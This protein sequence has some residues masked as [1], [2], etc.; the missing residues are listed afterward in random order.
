MAARARRA[1]SADRAD[2]QEL[3]FGRL[4]DELRE[5]RVN[6]REQFKPPQ[7]DGE[8]DIDLF[9]QHFQEVAEANGWNGMATLLHLR[10]ALQ[11]GAREYGRP[12]TTEEVF[13]A[14]RSRYGLT[15]KEA[16]GRLNGLKKEPRQS[17]HDHAIEVEKLVRKAFGD[18]PVEVQTNM[19]LDAFCSSLG[20]ATLQRHLLAIRPETLTEAVQHGQEYLQVKT[21]RNTVPSQVRALEETEEGKE[22]DPLSIL[23]ETVKQL[24][25]TVRELK[26]ASQKPSKPKGCW[27]CKKDGHVRKD[28]PTHPWEPKAKQTGNGDGPQ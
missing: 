25:D 23:M 27:G 1:V 6:R 21:D 2:P 11:G 20:N 3:L 12:A 28:C 17:L 14:L 15:T 26:Q 16:R 13:A 5:L 24:A 7:F 10:E 19:M 8:G 18:L 9:I 22:L 4:V